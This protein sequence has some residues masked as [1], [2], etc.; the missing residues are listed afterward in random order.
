MSYLSLLLPSATQGMSNDV[1]MGRE[2]EREVHA[3]QDAAE[4]ACSGT[5]GGSDHYRLPSGVT[6]LEHWLDLNG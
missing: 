5:G 2:I 6:S 3:V 1:G 4:N